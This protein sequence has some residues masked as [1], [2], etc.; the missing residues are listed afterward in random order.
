VPHD[1]LVRNGQVMLGDGLAWFGAK[2]A[3][4]LNLP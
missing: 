2:G 3:V 4:A 1:M